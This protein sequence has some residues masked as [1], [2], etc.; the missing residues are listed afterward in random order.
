MDAGHIYNATFFRA[1][2]RYAQLCFMQNCFTLAADLVHLI[3]SLNPTDELIACLA[4]FDFFLLVAGR[5]SVLCALC[6][7]TLE[8]LSGDHDL[9][10]L[11][12]VDAILM[13]W[14][15]NSYTSEVVTDETTGCSLSYGVKDLP[16]WWFSLA[17]AMFLSSISSS[18]SAKRAPVDQEQFG[19]VQAARS[20]QYLK[21]AMVRW[22]F[23]ALTLLNKIS[24][25]STATKTAS[26]S[27]LF[28]YDHPP[29]YVSVIAER[30][31][32]RTE[33]RY[34]NRAEVVSWVLETV[35]S[36]L[37]EQP[38]QISPSSYPSR[39]AARVFDQR[40]GSKYAQEM[41]FLEELPRLPQGMDP[42]NH[43]LMDPRILDGSVKFDKFDKHLLEL[44]G[45]FRRR[46]RMASTV[47]NYLWQRR[48]D[49]ENQ[50][51]GG[52]WNLT[53][54]LTLPLLQLFFLSLLPWFKI[55]RRTAP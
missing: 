6:G 36:L 14:E 54:D 35:N 48:S 29:S 10:R 11:P 44:K 12:T 26:K 28:L 37:T 21:A 24:P 32:E 9:H 4:Y 30:F 15:H 3:V 27:P 25:S 46:E 50:S 17:L 42:V 22:P 40:Y 45:H 18:T 34:W 23:V 1:L 49:N 53:L 51:T 5:Y 7:T 38:Q 41:M 31:I 33:E 13:Q 20:K 43:D 55:E 39:S 47:G 19:R 52:W 8:V 2:A 16:N